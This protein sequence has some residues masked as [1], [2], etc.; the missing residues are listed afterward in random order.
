[1]E[2]VEPEAAGEGLEGRAKASGGER[3]GG[4]EE[5]GGPNTSAKVKRL[6]RRR[7]SKGP[8]VEPRKSEIY[9]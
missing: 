9:R 7:A 6:G 8:K 2:R 3:D 5:V 1:M 4:M